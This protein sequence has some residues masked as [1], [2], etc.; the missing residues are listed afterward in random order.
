MGWRNPFRIEIDPD[1]DNLWVAD[2]SPDATKAKARRGPAGHGRWTVVRR[3]GQLRLAV[4]R[5]AEAALQRLQLHARAESGEK[6]DCAA[7]VNDVAHNTGLATPPAGRA[8]RG[9]VLVRQVEAVP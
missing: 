6:F 7:P 3:P 4:L 8:A 1:T 9:L 5:H 2:Y